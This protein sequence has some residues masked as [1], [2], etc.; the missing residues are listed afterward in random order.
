MVV[1]C[2]SV[3]AELLTCFTLASREICRKVASTKLLCL[4]LL[5]ASSEYECEDFQVISSE[6]ED[7]NEENEDTF[8]LGVSRWGRWWLF[9]KVKWFHKRCE[10]AYN[11][12]SEEAWYR[13]GIVEDVPWFHRHCEEL[14]ERYREGCGSE[15]EAEEALDDS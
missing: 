4:G 11:D 7:E 8:S 15:E 14:E 10:V 3:E 2:G 6:P 9:A 13:H 5:E 1:P 12:L